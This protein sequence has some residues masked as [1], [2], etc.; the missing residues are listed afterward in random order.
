MLYWTGGKYSSTSLLTTK[1]CS[2]VKYI[3]VW[4]F[5]HNNRHLHLTLKRDN[6][7]W[8]HNILVSCLV[9][10]KFTTSPN[11]WYIR[12]RFSLIS[13]PKKNK[14][15]V[16]SGWNGA[17]KLFILSFSHLFPNLIT[18][19]TGLAKHDQKAKKLTK[20]IFPTHLRV[21]FSFGKILSGQWSS[22]HV[23]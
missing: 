19:I 23:N 12:F 21:F 4:S 18:M 8:V 7:P 14:S 11:T 9:L 13:A 10:A 1:M 17:W 5:Q 2:S 20:E 16:I 15:D 22:Q 6:I 3:F